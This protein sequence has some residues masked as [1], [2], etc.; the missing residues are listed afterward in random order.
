MRHMRAILA[1]TAAITALATGASQ[2]QV[3]ATVTS[4]VPDGLKAGD[5]D[6]LVDEI[7]IDDPDALEHPYTST[8]VM[9]RDRYGQLLEFECAEND[10]NPVDQ[11]G[12]TQFK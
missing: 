11:Q 3:G 2:A 1:A 5:P 6:T 10:R 4:P 8:S 9:H 7:T 12:D